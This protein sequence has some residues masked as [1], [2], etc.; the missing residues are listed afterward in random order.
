MTIGEFKLWLE[1]NNITDEA[2]IMIN[3]PD[4]IFDAELERRSD[5]SVVF[6]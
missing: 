1:L 3:V 5:G 2:D 6:S 4:G